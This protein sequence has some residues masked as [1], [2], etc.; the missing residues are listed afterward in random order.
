MKANCQRCNKNIEISE[1]RI[2]TT[3]NILCD[4]CKEI[5]ERE[6]IK[7]REIAEENFL[8]H[9]DTDCFGNCFSDADPGL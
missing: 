2:Y 7:A 9:N 4:E 8:R 3:E 1:D 6:R 5:D